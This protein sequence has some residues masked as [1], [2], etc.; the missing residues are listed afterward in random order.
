MIDWEYCGMADPLTDLA[1]AAIYS[2]MSFEETKQLIELYRRAPMGGSDHAEVTSEE[3]TSRK[4]ATGEAQSLSETTTT[5]SGDEVE[6]GG[7]AL[8]GL[9]D[10]DAY[11]LVVAYMGLGGL[12]WALWCVY[13]M[14]LGESFGDYTLRMYRYFKDSYKFLRN[15]GKI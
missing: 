13:K 15:S 9:G 12:L 5:A 11:A 3:G 14:A 1:M 4:P 6:D 2:Y 8:R 10:E 7:I